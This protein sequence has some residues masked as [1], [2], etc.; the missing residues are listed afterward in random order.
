MKYKINEIFTSLKGEGVWLGEP[1]HFIRLATCNLACDHCDTR[2][3]DP[4]LYLSPEE[5]EK[6]L[7]RTGGIYRVVITGGEPTIQDLRPLATYLIEKGYSLHLESNGTKEF[8]YELFDWVCIS[9]KLDTSVP[10][11]VNLRYADE[12]KMPI[13]RE[14]DLV[15][16][17]EFR[18]RAEKVMEGW[19]EPSLSLQPCV[20]FLHPWNDKFE[21]EVV[22]SRMDEEGA[23]TMKG[24]SVDL[25]KLCVDHAIS[26]GRWRVSLQAHK[27]WAIR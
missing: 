18:K 7:D 5:I 2:F 16:A 20:W 23:R 9:P 15:R 6:Q 1:M 8:P 19:K 26:S 12:I 25:N 3:N 21:Q 17:E 14:S 24:W 13:V 10:L 27:I 22:G 4:I 11:D